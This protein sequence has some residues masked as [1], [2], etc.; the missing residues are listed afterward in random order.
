M[1]PHKNSKNGS[2]SP[3]VHTKKSVLVQ[4]ENEAKA[5]KPM[6]VFDKVCED[7][8]GVVGTESCGSV[9]QNKKQVSN[10][11][12]SI[13]KEPGDADPLF[14]V[15]EECKKEQSHADPFIRAVKAVPEAMCVLARDRQLNDMARFCT[16]DQQF[17]VVGVDPTFNLGEFSVTVTAYRHLQFIHRQTN[18][19][20]ILL[21]PM[22]LHQNKTF[23]SYY[24]LASTVVGLCQQL[25]DCF[26]NRWRANP[27]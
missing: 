24:F 27:R 1:R 21:G 18:K 22:L 9:P 2:V 11:K 6:H 14:A 13:K 26:W 23:E 25:S 15:M 12:R 4:I 10:V 19:H 16:D 7:C 17:S 3:Y 8:G 20:P 5:S